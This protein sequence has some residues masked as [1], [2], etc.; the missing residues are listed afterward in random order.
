VRLRNISFGY[1]I[2]KPVLNRLKVD[3]LRVYF[4]AQNL[5]TFTKYTGW[6]PEVSTDAV[7]GN[8]AAGQDFYS[9][10][11]AKTLTV[12]LQIGF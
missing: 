2:P 11:Q 7:S 9:A 4:L 1:T 12:G 6:D 8:I 3:R 5:L 10:P